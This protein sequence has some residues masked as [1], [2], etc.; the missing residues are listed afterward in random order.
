VTRT[1]RAL[2]WLGL[3]RLQV[4]RRWVGGRWAQTCPYTGHY[5]SA[6]VLR[7]QYDPDA[8]IRMDEDDR[9]VAVE[10]WGRIELPRASITSARLAGAAGGGH[11]DQAQEEARLRL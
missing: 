6:C 3:G 8:K 10:Q 9:V 7:W 4:F 11:D 2:F 5:G 1:Q